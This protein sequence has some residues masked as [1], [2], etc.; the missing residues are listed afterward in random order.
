M[1]ASPLLTGITTVEVQLPGARSTKLY[2]HDAIVSSVP[3]F[4][5]QKERWALE[6]ESLK[7]TLP[8]NVC[9]EAVAFVLEGLYCPG[10]LLHRGAST[11]TAMVLQMVQVASML[12][13]SAEIIQGLCK[14]LQDSLS[15]END[16]G[17]LCEF[18][19]MH[20]VP[21]AVSDVARRCLQQDAA[22][23]SQHQLLELLKHGIEKSDA[24]IL[25][26]VQRHLKKWSRRGGCSRVAVAEILTEARQPLWTRAGT[27]QETVMTLAA[28]FVEAHPPF[29]EQLV[30]A[31]FHAQVLQAHVLR[32]HAPGRDVVQ[33]IRPSLA[34]WFHRFALVGIRHIE[35]NALSIE[36]FVSFFRFVCESAKVRVTRDL[37]SFLDGTLILIEE[38]LQEFIQLLPRMQPPTQ[39]RIWQAFVASVMSSWDKC[40]FVRVELLEQLAPEAK[41]IFTEH[42]A[43]LSPDCLSPVLTLPVLEHFNTSDKMQL[44]TRASCFNAEVK[45]VLLRAITPLDDDSDDGF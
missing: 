15:S 29:Y 19:A 22:E 5:A 42:I 33:H 43:G 21:K 30:F 18:C 37:S 40:K 23:L 27:P 2:I 7:L 41:R 44:V 9:I 8:D 17:T 31:M 11:G 26:L 35:D 12:D 32:G 14:V 13:C 36:A 39:V 10:S 20:E 24:E 1:Q 16:L 4:H 45:A 25:A 34:K 3:Y 6:Q 38:C 28:E